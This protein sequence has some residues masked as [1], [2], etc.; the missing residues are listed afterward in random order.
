MI[1]AETKSIMVIFVSVDFSNPIN[2]LDDPTIYKNFCEKSPIKPILL[3]FCRIP[4]KPRYLKSNY[5][6]L[7]SYFY[8]RGDRH[9]V[10]L[11]NRNLSNQELAFRSNINKS[12]RIDR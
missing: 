9:V 11:Q 8:A 6:V 3:R 2:M 1:I 5:L 12:T 10:P 7:S 4:R